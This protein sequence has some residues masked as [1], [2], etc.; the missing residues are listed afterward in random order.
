MKA[1]ELNVEKDSEI[2]LAENTFACCAALH[3][4]VFARKHGSLIGRMEECKCGYLYSHLV[5]RSSDS[6]LY[7]PITE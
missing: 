6:K 7:L 4:I 1:R 2:T 3:D 5:R